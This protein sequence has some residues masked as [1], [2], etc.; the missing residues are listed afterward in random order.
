[1]PLK[2]ITSQKPT[3]PRA[4]EAA[5]E[6]SLAGIRLSRASQPE[7]QAPLEDGPQ[8]LTVLPPQPEL[9]SRLVKFIKKI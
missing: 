5:L 6:V 1:M 2:P 4:F 8:Q 7:G 3:E 9:V